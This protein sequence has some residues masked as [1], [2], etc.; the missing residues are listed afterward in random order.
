MG[1]SPGVSWPLPHLGSLKIL[2]LGAQK[3]NPACPKLYIALA[4]TAMAAPTENQRVL[5][6]AAAVTITCGKLVAEGMVPLKETPGPLVA[7]PWRDSDH[8]S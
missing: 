8:H 1:S 3:V 7:M 4:S 2:I 5:L 6:K